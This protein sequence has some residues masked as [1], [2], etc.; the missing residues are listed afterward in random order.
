M[1]P[2]HTS[3]FGATAW[4]VM[5]VMLG[6]SGSVLAGPGGGSEHEAA[7]FVKTAD[8]G[9]GDPQNNYAFSSAQLRGD[10]FVGT[11]RNFLF[12]IF[13]GLIAAGI[14][15][16]DY[17][18]QYI[19]HSDEPSWSEAR[20]ED[21][22]AEIWRQRNRGGVWE[23]VYRSRPAD[24]S[25]VGYPG[26]PPEA[27]AAREPGFRSMTSFIDKWGDEAI[28]AASAAS[29]VPGRLLIKSS[30]GESW[31]DVVTF[32]TIPEGDSRSIA[33]H[34]GKLYVGPAG[35]GTARLWATDDPSSTGDSS[36]WKLMAD[37]TNQGSGTN[38]AV[39]SL[40][41]WRGFLYAGTQNDDAGFQLWRSDAQSPED[42]SVSGWTQIIDS[43]AGD[44]AS[45]RALTMT[46]FDDALIVG[47]S[48]FP[49]SVQPPFLLPL[50][51]FEVIR[52]AE[53]DSWELMVGDYFAQ[54]PVGGVPTLR[55]PR[56]GWPGGFANF[57]NLYCWSLHSYRGVLYLGS[58][59]TTSFLAVVFGTNAT[60]DPP[61]VPD[62]S[63]QQ[64]ALLQSVDWLDAL[65]D[66]ELPP[67]YRE[68]RAAV[69][70]PDPSQIDWAAVW[71]LI[72]GRFAGA[73]LWRTTDLV[74]WE[75]VTL[76]G[77]DD[78]T[79]YGFR[80][81][82]RHRAFY[83]GTANPFEGLEIHEAFPGHR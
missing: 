66:E 45:T 10:V 8:D 36:N 54:R 46:V 59:D 70:V 51:G 55:V 43:G 62:V 82:L 47:T 44:M 76:N 6:V 4:V 34:N 5:A 56:S 72:L 38:V 69:D 71:Q 58:F 14:L 80:T 63:A 20:A 7:D 40:V 19:T 35:T 23:K 3:L 9:F 18:Y 32:P 73:D 48:M 42:P 57:L 31:E 1:K 2:V 33:V 41:S 27:W 83:V 49:L 16:P 12:R 37:F 13:E 39:V 22:S 15:P 74:H 52:V 53:D 60:V 24:V 67:A 75:P 11:G 28:Y 68:L 25:A 50:K 64:A 29:L 79:N 65:P 21:M 78:P 61:L 30:D 26:A 17:E 77:F 81:M